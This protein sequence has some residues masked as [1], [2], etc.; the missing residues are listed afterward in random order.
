LSFRT[1]LNLFFVLLVVAPLFAVGV[2]LLRTIDGAAQGRVESALASEGRYAS[3]VSDDLRDDAEQVSRTVATDTRL[4]AAMRSGDPERVRR[5]A[6]QLVAP[7][8]AARRIRIALRSGGAV[9]VGSDTAVLP[10]RNDLVTRAGQPLATLDVSVVEG[11]DLAVRLQRLTGRTVQVVDSPSGRVLGGTTRRVTGLPAPGRVAE[12]AGGDWTA[13]RL[14]EAGFGASDTDVVLLARAA[15]SRAST[16]ERL[17]LVGTLLVFLVL[18]GAGALIISRSL[19]RQVENLLEG[20]RRLGR[21]DFDHEIP[22]GGGADEFGQLA[23]GFNAMSRQLRRRMEELEAERVRLRAAMRRIG[24]TFAANLDREGLLEIVTRAAADG[25][26]GDVSRAVVV[27][28]DREEVAETGATWAYDALLRRAAEQATAAGHEVLIS[29]GDRHAV[30]VVMDAAGLR[31][32]VVVARTGMPFTSQDAEMV[33]YLSGQAAV[34]LE[35]V[36]RHEEVEREA[37][38]D[39]LT[40]LANRRR[41]DELLALAIDEA[42]REGRPVSLLALDLDH[43]K[44]VNDEHGHGVGDEVLMAMARALRETVRGGDVAARLGGEEF[45]VLLPRTD[46]HGAVILGERLREAVAELRVPTP[47]GVTIRVTTSVG[48][49]TLDG[50]AID[51]PRLIAAA[52]G[53]LYRAKRAGRNRTVTADVSAEH[54]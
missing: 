9:E 52:D 12:I 36:G 17:A 40:G 1:R 51:A 47:T 54:G 22:G 8:T 28:G 23:D 24:E 32:T 6:A 11:A 39:P 38:T 29:E 7:A 2:V 16:G 35:N 10:R 53:A 14:R 18:A 19:Q 41:F 45:A 13:V 3:R 20:S 37:H 31:G 27:A 34:S 26:R 46:T 43:F 50:D 25:V 15:E 33:G 42:H 48:S 21:G 4:A 49:A 44:D 5:R 30:A